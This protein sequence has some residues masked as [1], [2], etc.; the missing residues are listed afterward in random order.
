M[1][2]D[3]QTEGQ[4]NDSPHK[5]YIP[6]HQIDTVVPLVVDGVDVNDGNLVEQQVGGA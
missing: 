3:G 4:T 5:K 2:P 6:Q 1:S